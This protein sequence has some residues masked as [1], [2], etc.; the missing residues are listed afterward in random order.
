MRV[1]YHQQINEYS[2]GP[3]ALQM[4]L[5]YFGQEV[6]QKKLAR[7]VHASRASGTSHAELLRAARRRGFFAYLNDNSTLFEIKHFLA[8]GLPVIVNFIDAASDE[9]HYAVVVGYRGRWLRLNDPWNGRNFQLSDREFLNRWHDSRNQ[10]REWIMVLAERDFRLGKQFLP[11]RLAG[12][13]G[14]S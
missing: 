11:R 3:A 10:H 1:P 9:G 8:L 6:S 12:R 14:Q 2:C 4:V 5:E 7:A 13:A